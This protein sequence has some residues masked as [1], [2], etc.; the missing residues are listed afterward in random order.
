MASVQVSVGRGLAIHPPAPMVPPRGQ[1]TFTTT[2]GSGTGIVWA[3]A[4]NASGA[5]ISDGS[6][7]AGAMGNVTDVVT[8]TDSDGNTATAHVSVEPGAATGADAGPDAGTDA[9]SGA[10]TDA[11]TTNEAGGEPNSASGAGGGCGCRTAGHERGAPPSAWLVGLALGA[12]IVRRRRPA[13]PV[14]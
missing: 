1:V 6:Y 9:G 3:I 13:P 12:A 7:T 8:A 2:G 14:T 10:S 5:T 4:S 11:G